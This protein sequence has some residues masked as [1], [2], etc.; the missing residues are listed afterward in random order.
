MVPLQMGNVVSS[1]NAVANKAFKMPAIYASAVKEQHELR[2]K[3]NKQSLFHKSVQEVLEKVLSGFVKS[4]TSFGSSDTFI[5]GFELEEEVELGGDD[6][7]LLRAD[8]KA[9]LKLAHGKTLDLIVEVDGAKHFC[10]HLR[11][12]GRE[13]P[14]RT[15][16]HNG[17]T[18]LRDRLF[19]LAIAESSDNHVVCQLAVAQYSW[20]EIEAG[21]RE[22]VTEERVAVLK[23]LV[24]DALG[25][26]LGEESSA[27]KR[28]KIG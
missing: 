19:D 4:I 17:P 8:M 21:W 25:T 24:S 18:H 11:N 1:M 28:R 5:A 16:Y 20:P 12:R 9:S 2:T 14:S 27:K 3:G 26:A 6:V 15:F 13:S 23:T 10:T 22:N 7:P